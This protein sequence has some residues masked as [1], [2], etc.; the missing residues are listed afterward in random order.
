MHAVPIR[1]SS[2][3]LIEHM[4]STGHQ[5]PN[6]IWMIVHSTGHQAP[7]LYIWMIIHS[8]GH[9]APNLYEY[10]W[11]QQLNQQQR[12]TSATWQLR[13]YNLMNIHHLIATSYNH[14]DNCNIGMHIIIHQ[15]IYIPS[16]NISSTSYSYNNHHIY[17]YINS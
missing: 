12:K 14:Q 16:C 4:L 10:A 1:A 11:T 13:H 6:F 8:T 5:A 3:Q 9:Q 17:T 2:P 15:R 7:N